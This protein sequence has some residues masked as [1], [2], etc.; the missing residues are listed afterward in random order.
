MNGHGQPLMPHDK[1]DTDRSRP[2]FKPGCRRL[3]ASVSPDE[4]Q[5]VGDSCS[6][7]AV[8]LPSKK[9]DSELVRAIEMS[10]LPAEAKAAPTPRSQALLGNV[11]LEALL[12][13][14]LSQAGKQSFPGGAF[15][16]RAWERG[17]TWYRRVGSG[18]RQDP[19][20][21][22]R[23]RLLR[24]N[25]GDIASQ[26]H[27]KIIDFS[28]GLNPTGVAMR[29]RHALPSSKPGSSPHCP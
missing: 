18:T 10:D 13:Q 21:L 9:P 2:D 4:N 29:P 26:S 24:G 16:S 27:G 5:N 19:T 1:K 25:Q 28:S 23:R 11:S 22:D 3:P 17:E 14:K 8:S 7:L 20:A 6:A 15:P 12:L